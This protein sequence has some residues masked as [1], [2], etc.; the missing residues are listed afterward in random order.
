MAGAKNLSDRTEYWRLLDAAHHIHPFTQTDALNREGVRV[1]VR[2]K[3]IYIWDSDGHRLIDGM[4]GLWCMQLGYGNKELARAGFEALSTLP[5]YNHFFKTTN[6]WT[7]E[8]AAKLA[9]ILPAG[10]SRILF[11]NSGSEANDTALKLIRYY[12]NRMGKPD[13]KLHLSRA[14][15]YHGVTMAA[16]SLSGITPMHPQWDL[17][18][19]GFVKAPAPY[20][21]GAKQAG[22]GDMEEDEF[23]HRIARETEEEIL[24]IGPERIASFSAEPIQGAGG[25]IVPPAT[26]WP[27]IA[28]L[29]KKYDILLHTDEV[30]TGF[31]RIGDWFASH[32]YGLKPDIMT[33]A[34]GMSS[35]YQPISAVSLGTRM[36][37][38]IAA[39]DEELVHGYTYSGHP[40]A[41]AVALKNIEILDR[42]G[43]VARVKDSIGPYF[44][45]RLREIFD[46]HGLVGEVRGLGLIAAIELVEDRNERRPFPKER[47][48]GT[49]C[50]DHCFRN[51]LVMRAIRDTMVLAP[52]L[53]I[54]EDEIE[55]LLA[56][57]K[58][59][60]D[61]TAKDLKRT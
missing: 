4:A 50:R 38:V 49:I 47:G 7:V 11:A 56:K 51:G 26:Y 54:T 58:R 39:A 40:V 23:G 45:R 57:A 8:L 19:P 12:W 14:L 59:C 6:P 37:E 46:G 31:G 18:L 24:R 27:E 3:G 61:L 29:L 35:G 30:I 34:K 41:S 42:D 44:Q 1:I 60:I 43:L 52:P 25:M 53:I 13:K 15:S 16:A 55:K 9:T 22:Y 5:Y 28:Q 32:H 17:P 33:M 21:Y 36:G 48:A 10:H 2:G 20:W